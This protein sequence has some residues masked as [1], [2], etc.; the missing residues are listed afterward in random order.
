MVEDTK[1][2]P[3]LKGFFSLSNLRIIW[4]AQADK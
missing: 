2:N 3:G 1:G 4:Y